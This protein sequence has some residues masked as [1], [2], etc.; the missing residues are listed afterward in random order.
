MIWNCLG[1]QTRACGHALTSKHCSSSGNC[2][3]CIQQC[4]DEAKPVVALVKSGDYKAIEAWLLANSHK[5]DMLIKGGVVESVLSLPTSQARSILFMFK[6]NGV[7]LNERMGFEDFHYNPITFCC[8][9]GISRLGILMYVCFIL[10]SSLCNYSMVMH[11]I[12]Y[13]NKQ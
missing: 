11:S 4:R 2:D 9:H 7:N 13:S 6:A 12:Y 10:V 5:K 8:R 1:F 3:V